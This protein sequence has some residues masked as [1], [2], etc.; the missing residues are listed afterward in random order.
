M[1][2][3][4]CKA[5]LILI[6]FYLLFVIKGKNND[7]AEINTN[8]KVLQI[9][10]EKQQLENNV[11]KLKTDQFQYLNDSILQK[12]DSV[13]KILKI[14]DTELK[15]LAYQQNNFSKK[16]SIIFK[17][18]FLI[19]NTSIDT[20]VGDEWFATCLRVEYP[21]SIYLEPSIQSLQYIYI[22]NKREI[23][24]KPRKTWLGRLFQRKQLV[25]KVQTIEKN[26]Y[27]NKQNEV[28][29]ETE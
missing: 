3:Y 25:T 19:E 20:V 21:N 9:N 23:I 8:Y 22:Y 27:I 10:Y 16:D 15:Y 7:I 26:P 28:F 24:G 6:C 1:K 18:T 12:L 14:K 4:L 11:L 17:D 13:R 29:I 2:K 5:I